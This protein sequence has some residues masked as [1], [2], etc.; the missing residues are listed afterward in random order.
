MIELLDRNLS[1][2]EVLRFKRVLWS[3]KL[4]RFTSND[5]EPCH[6]AANALKREAEQKRE[7]K[8]EAGH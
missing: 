8:S 1:L 7:K 2:M 3:P 6:W 5:H 4:S